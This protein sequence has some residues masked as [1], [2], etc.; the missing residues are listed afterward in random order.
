MIAS[1]S[2]SRS[3]VVQ[4]PE[5]VKPSAGLDATAYHSLNFAHRED[6]AFWA[7]DWIV[8]GTQAD[9]PHGG[10]LLPFTV[11]DHAVHIQRNTDGSLVGRF[12]QAQHGGCRVVPLQCQQ[13]TKTP[14]SFTSCGH[15]LDRLPLQASELG[16]TTSEMHQ[17][18][19][20]RPE[21]LLPVRTARFGPLLFVN[22]D[23][24]AD[25]FDAGARALHQTLPELSAP[26]LQ[27]VAQTWIDFAGN[28]KLVGQRL[29]SLAGNGVSH[30]RITADNLALISNA[31]S[32]AVWCF[33]NLLMLVRPGSICVVVLQPIAT[34]RTRCRVS[35]FSGAGQAVPDPWGALLGEKRA[36]IEQTQR[37]LE[38]FNPAFPTAMPESLQ[39][40]ASEALGAWVGEFVQTRLRDQAAE[41]ASISSDFAIP[42]RRMQ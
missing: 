2:S 24:F 19:G 32:S 13:G 27:R 14:C 16:G 40:L 33:P 42:L 15:S 20:L 22:L 28:W 4:P 26:S 35:V 38:A 30:V 21:R 18:L 9:V 7:R 37:A 8:V 10:D 23:P 36:E 31:Q 17:Y 3:A 1:K 25:S 39:M 34:N 12:N 41:S 6:R 5:K 29:A 11:G